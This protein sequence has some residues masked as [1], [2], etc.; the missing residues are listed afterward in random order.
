LKIGI[1]LFQGKLSAHFGHCPEVAMVE[2]DLTT[3]TILN[4]QVI[5]TPPH[6]PGR[7]PGWLRAEGA[8]MV[9]AGG[10]GQR[11]MD[12]FRQAGVQVIVGVASDTPEVIVGAWLTGRLQTGDN[13]C[14][15][16]TKETHACGS[17]NA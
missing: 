16:D 9:I 6:E 11:A 4:I 13:G 5:P 10:M 17:T 3:K 12:L 7:F 8:D 14:N 15:H 1:P 2:V